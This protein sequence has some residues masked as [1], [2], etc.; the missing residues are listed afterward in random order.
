MGRLG[1]FW[2][3]LLEKMGILDFLGDGCLGCF[4]MLPLPPFVGQFMNP[5]NCFS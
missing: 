3:Q 4:S 5:E 1:A 2:E